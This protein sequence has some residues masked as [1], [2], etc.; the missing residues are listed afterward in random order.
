MQILSAG[1]GLGVCHMNSESV[2]GK[3]DDFPLQSHCDLLS[4]LLFCQSPVCEVAPLL[5][6]AAV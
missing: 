6:Y 5:A 4:R 3:P 2:A 1:L